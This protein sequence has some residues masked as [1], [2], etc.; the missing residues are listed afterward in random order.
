MKAEVRLLYIFMFILLSLGAYS[1]DNTN[2]QAYVAC[3]HVRDVQSYALDT[4][5]RSEKT[6]PTI[7]YYKN[8][9]HRQELAVQLLN[10]KEAEKNF[11]PIHC[12]RKI[13]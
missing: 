13:I 3:R 4:I 9:D 11:T 1:I 12:H 8:P 6:L 7:A 10:L 2:E 5:Q